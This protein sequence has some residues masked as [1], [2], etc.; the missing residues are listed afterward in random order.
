VSASSCTSYKNVP[1][2]KDLPDSARAAIMNA[3]YKELVIKPD[4]ILNINIQ[5]IDPTANA[6]FG[7]NTASPLGQVNN[8]VSLS[9]SQQQSLL[10]AYLVDKNG[11]VELPILGK[12]TLG[13]LTTKQARDTIQEHA[14]VYYKSP[15]VNVRFA[16][17]KITVLGEVQHPGTFVLAN[18]KN[19]IFDALGLAG[20]LTIFGKRENMLLIRDSSGQSQLIRFS[21]NSTNL[22]RENFFYLKQNDVIYVEPNQSKIASLDASKTRLYT[23]TA[24]VLSLLIVIATRIK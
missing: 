10:T 16:N 13:G 14:S 23:I 17:L 24:A 11:E 2:F 9:S 21:L 1:Y 3:P 4:D 5:T 20:D 12:L 7:Q 18:E 22:M 8:S 15:T 19:T 6:I